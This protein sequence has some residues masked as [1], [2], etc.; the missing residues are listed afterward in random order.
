[1]TRRPMP[2]RR[3]RGF[4]GASRDVTRCA[5]GR[6]AVRGSGLLA[7][8]ISLL[9]QSHALSE[10]WPGWRGPRGD[11][12]SLETNVPIH[13]G[14]ASNLVWKT[15]LPGGGH[16]SPIIWENRVFTVAARPET[17]ERVLLC[18]DAA[19]GDL[20][21]ERTVVRTPL[22]KKHGLNSHAS[23]TPATD[24]VR[25]YTAF[26][27]V[28][29]MVVSAHDLS[30]EQI[31]QVRPGPFRSVHGFCSS[32]VV[33][34]ERV[35]VNGDH[36]GDG[37]I[38]ALDRRTGAQVWKID[39]PNKTRSYCVPTLFDTAGR[40]QMVLSGTMCVTGY[41]PEDGK[42]L[43]TIDGPTE[44]FVA[45]LVYSPRANLLFMTG[46]YPEHH[47]LAIKPDG[48]GNV[49]GTHI[50]WRTNKASCVA[51]VPSPIVEGDYLLV[52]S[53]PGFANCL[54]AATG[55]ILWQERLGEHHASLISANGLVYFLSDEGVTTVV[56]PGPTFERVAR[57]EIGER[58]FA[59][60]AVSGGRLFLRGDRHL[61]CVGRPKDAGL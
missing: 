4:E 57:N 44:Q 15:P 3:A 31:W 52:V 28:Q 17:E 32:P 40:R 33:D 54:Q 43:W 53:D 30:G 16:A 14:L 46:G 38:V 42:L 55:R 48:S 35:I 11:G 25:V 13:W 1:M 29:D 22:E 39:R 19:R 10:N 45:S 51:Y 56:R 26:L 34:G 50:A 5:P 18:L 61:F 23:S 9:L 41:N 12:S 49:T 6:R 47:L 21:W 2:V 27:D 58:C 7:V 37:Y 59:S 36:D 20:Q 24:G 60:P 8:L